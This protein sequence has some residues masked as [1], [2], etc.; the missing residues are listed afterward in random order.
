LVMYIITLEPIPTSYFITS[1][2]QPACL[3]GYP[4][5]V[6]T[7]LLVKNVTATMNTHATIKEFLDVFSVRPVS[8]QGKYAINSSQNFLCFNA[9]DR[10]TLK[11]WSII[12][13]F[14]IN[15]R[16]KKRWD[17]IRKVTLWKTGKV[18]SV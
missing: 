17:S 2:H 11:V 16:L 8:Y 5:I 6:A 9:L 15:C 7:Q 18:N 14:Y 4:R 3:H 13:A 1:C 10:A 12:V